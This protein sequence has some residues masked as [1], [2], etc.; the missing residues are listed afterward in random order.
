MR[1]VI[2]SFIH[3][4]ESLDTRTRELLAATPDDVLY[5]PISVEGKMAAVSIAS[6]IL[7]SAAMVE[8]TFGGISTRLWDD[9]FE[10]TLPEKLNDRKLILEYLDEVTATRRYGFEYFRDD[11]DLTKQI[12]APET[13]KTLHDILNDT[14]LSADSHLLCAAAISEMG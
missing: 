5:R 14:L 8:K 12:P 10:W 1:I 9:P 13:L 2:E 11:A 3:K 7:R 6:S 4:F